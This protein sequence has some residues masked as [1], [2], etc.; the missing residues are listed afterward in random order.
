MDSYA[1][2]EPLPSHDMEPDVDRLQVEVENEIR[3]GQLV[4]SYRLH[5][6]TLT[7]HDRNS[8]VLVTARRGNEFTEFGYML[9]REPGG[10]RLVFTCGGLGG[11]KIFFESSM[12]KDTIRNTM[13]SALVETASH[14]L[15]TTTHT[16]S[17][18]S[19]SGAEVLYQDEDIVLVATASDTDV[20]Y[21]IGVRSR[22]GADI[23]SR[24]GNT[25]TAEITGSTLRIGASTYPVVDSISVLACVRQHVLDQVNA[26][27]AASEPSPD[28]EP[29]SSEIFT[30]YHTEF[31]AWARKNP[32]KIMYT[33]KGYQVHVDGSGE[34]ENDRGLIP[35][36][37]TRNGVKLHGHDDDNDFEWPVPLVRFYMKNRQVFEFQVILPILSAYDDVE[38]K[39]PVVKAQ[40][41]PEVV[42]KVLAKALPRL[43]D[44][45]PDHGTATASATSFA[46][47]FARSIGADGK[48]LVGKTV[49]GVEILDVEVLENADVVSLRC[50]TETGSLFL[51]ANEAGTVTV[52]AF[53]GVRLRT[54]TVT[55]KSAKLNI[56]VEALESNGNEDQEPPASAPAEEP[57]ESEE[58]VAEAAAEPGGAGIS[59]VFAHL[60]NLKFRTKH[61]AVEI[62]HVARPTVDDQQNMYLLGTVKPDDHAQLLYGTPNFQYG[63]SVTTRLKNTASE[64]YL[65]MPQVYPNPEAPVTVQHGMHIGTSTDD[66]SA[67]AR[68]LVKV[69]RVWLQKL[70]QKV[71]D[72]EH[73]PALLMTLQKLDQYESRCYTA[74]VL[75][76]VQKKPGPYITY[77]R[78]IKISLKPAVLDQILDEDLQGPLNPFQ[79]A[80]YAWPSFLAGPTLQ[81]AFEAGPEAYGARFVVDT[82]KHQDDVDKTQVESIFSKWL[83]EYMVELDRGIIDNSHQEKQEDADQG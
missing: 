23:V 44:K 63:F 33:Y 14:K 13:I 56:V 32:S 62:N 65:K 16:T 82:K 47:V 34:R 77:G 48:K 45:L 39:V 20:G 6:L 29:T 31:A 60:S 22:Y 11:K 79:F 80:C 27:T 18:S 15:N 52:Q 19:T 28:E 53:A 74:H 55:P 5:G 8:Y 4:Y 7:L 69:M 40:Q 46:T 25:G 75:P 54:T 70:D 24:L 10:H 58:Q 51:A 64:V 42:A 72:A 76:G 57:S 73:I 41:L 50:R 12:S 68:G 81:V 36:Y 49:F 3:H 43:I 2:A 37:M 30:A 59:A 78:T 17:A 1:A 38:V 66:V 83:R 35:L 61:F 21:E 26:P 9:F 67:L 71:E